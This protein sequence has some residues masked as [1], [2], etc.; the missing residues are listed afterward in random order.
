MKY[1]Y[2]F[3][4]ITVRSNDKAKLSKTPHGERLLFAECIVQTVY[5]SHTAHDARFALDQLIGSY[6]IDI[7]TNG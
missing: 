2:I 5:E 6:S 1:V 4:G 7:R 3:P